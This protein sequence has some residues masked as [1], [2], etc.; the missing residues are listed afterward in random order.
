MMADGRDKVPDWADLVLWPRSSGPCLSRLAW[1]PVG[2]HQHQD[3]DA[4]E[5]GVHT[6]V[7][8]K[9][10][11]PGSKTSKQEYSAALAVWGMRE[12]T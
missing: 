2:L 8:W 9:E 5:T 1:V 6:E 7:G 11:I 4:M 3:G 12:A 10:E